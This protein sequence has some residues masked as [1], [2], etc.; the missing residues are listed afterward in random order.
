MT[1]GTNILPIV[2]LFIEPNFFIPVNRKDAEKYKSILVKNISGIDSRIETKE[3]RDVKSNNSVLCFVETINNFRIYTR[4]EEPK[5]F[6]VK[7]PELFFE[8]N[9]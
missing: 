7:N 2:F 9:T 8:S 6:S 1:T 4:V 3:L 5:N